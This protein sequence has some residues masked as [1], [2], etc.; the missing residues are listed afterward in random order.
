MGAPGPGGAATFGAAATAGGTGE[1]GAWRPDRETQGA[2]GR[3]THEGGQRGGQGEE[4]TGSDQA[5]RP[6]ARAAGSQT[7]GWGAGPPAAPGASARHPEAR[8]PVGGPQAEEVETESPRVNT[9]QSGHNQRE[10]GPVSSKSG[11]C[12]QILTECLEWGAGPKLATTLPLFTSAA[13]PL[14]I[15]VQAGQRSWQ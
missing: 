3:A 4:T 1:G 8:Q 14:C 2:C 11:T 6:W 12:H 13:H 10:S 7:A 9:S 15:C 5:R